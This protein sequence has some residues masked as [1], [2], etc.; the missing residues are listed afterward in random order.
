MLATA[1]VLWFGGTWVA[2]D[3]SVSNPRI[4]ILDEATASVATLTEAYIQ[5]AVERLLA[6]RTAIVVAHRLSTVRHAELICVVQ[7][8]KIVEQSPHA[9]LL[10]RDG[11]YRKLYEKQLSNRSPHPATA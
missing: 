10:S 9:E 4:L 8:G 3:L 6:E 7:D 2:G 5:D 11:V 1:V